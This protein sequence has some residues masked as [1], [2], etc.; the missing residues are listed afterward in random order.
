MIDQHPTPI[1]TVRRVKDLP[2]LFS[3]GFLLLIAAC[4][5]LADLLP[6]AYPPEYL[7]LSAVYRPPFQSSG[8]GGANPVHW[9]GTDRLGRDVLSNVIYGC[10]TALL[11][12]LPAM[13]LATALGLILGGMAGYYGNASIRIHPVTIATGLVFSLPAG[14]YGFYLRKFALSEAFQQTVLSG[15]AASG[16][17]ILIVLLILLAGAGVSMGIR[18]ILP[19]GRM[20]YFPLDQVVLKSI[21]LVT[22]VP[23]L[24]LVLCL[25]AYTQP[26]ITNVILIAGLTFWTEPA[27]LIRAE[28]LRIKATHYIESA[29]ALGLQDFRIL[30]RHAIPNALSS[31]LVAGTFGIV[32]LI[33]LE[34]TLSFL[35][36]GVPP[37]TASWGRLVGSARSNFSAWW[38]VVFPGLT[39]CL[40][41]LSLQ[42]CTNHLIRRLDPRR[43]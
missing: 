32:S 13:L 33:S 31:V 11:V 9:L 10:R 1:R 21:E 22:S 37:D 3:A 23:R 25:A 39:L 4:A 34:A 2:L 7:D 6:L 5:L 42:T 41:V 36:I 43:R 38:L 12:S 27:R 20:M 40:T 17:S 26:S 35:N 16:V 29:K 15:V 24:M 30:I 14:F 8:N 28:I 18:R 19:V